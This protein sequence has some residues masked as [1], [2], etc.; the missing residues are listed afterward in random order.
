[1][2]NK[3][4]ILL[5]TTAL[6]ASLCTGCGASMEQSN[7]SYGDA[8]DSSYNT[9]ISSDFASVSGFGGSSNIK[10]SYSE[11]KMDSYTE[12]AVSIEEPT[13][14]DSQ[15]NIEADMTLVEEK[16]VYY[17]DLNIE[18]K[19]YSETYD[20]IK[21]LIVQYGGLVQSESQ[22]DNAYDWYCSTYR[23]ASASLKTHISCRIPSK[24]YDEFVNGISNLDTENNKIKSKSTRIENISQEYYDN[25]TQ[26]EALE[27]QEARLLEMMEQAETIE[28]M[29]T[30]EDRLTTVQSKLNRLNTKLVYMDMDVAYSYVNIS[31]NEVKEY[32]YEFEETTFFSRM[33]NEIVD[34]WEL[35][36][37]LFEGLLSTIFHLIPILL[38]V[39]LPIILV[40]ILLIKIVIALIKRADKK[41]KFLNGVKKVFI[42]DTEALKKLEE[43]N[44]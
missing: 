37:E 20:S 28:D 23:D 34:A 18:T 15:Q 22:S 29:I 9:S 14:D 10:G 27:I 41:H 39:V 12:E 42:G 2:K 7:G 35:T 5:L 43:Q 6:I 32:T 31:L 8:Y 38:L 16:L 30:V 1:M 3:K 21:A 25:K 33:W 40:F 4:G 19:T 44:K 36:G 17:C 13:F 24:N 26:I 11:S